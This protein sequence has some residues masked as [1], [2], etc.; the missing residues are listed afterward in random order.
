LQILSLLFS[1]CLGTIYVLAVYLAVYEI[2]QLA[3]ITA[4]LA[5]I[6]ASQIKVDDPSF[7]TDADGWRSFKD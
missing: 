3:K 6:T 2:A 5:K 4:Q 1:N 7:S